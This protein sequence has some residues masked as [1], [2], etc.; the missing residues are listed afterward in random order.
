[1]SRERSEKKRTN[2]R[3][4]P[5][6]GRP[7][8]GNGD[9][10]NVY[11]IGSS[12]LS[13]NKKRVSSCAVVQ[14]A[15]LSALDAGRKHKCSAGAPFDEAPMARKFLKMFAPSS[16]MKKAAAGKGHGKK[17]SGNG[18]LKCTPWKRTSDL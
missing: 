5:P 12:L 15:E 6:A 11:P 1:M 9:D 8:P 3:V 13:E 2:K 17:E 16:Q 10:L 7:G 18:R 4:A 14:R